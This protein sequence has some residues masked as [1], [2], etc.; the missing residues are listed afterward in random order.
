MPRQPDHIQTEFVRP[1]GR[2]VEVDEGL[3]NILDALRDHGVWTQYS[4]EGTGTKQAAYILADKKTFSPFLA[5]VFRMYKKGNLSAESTALVSSFLMGW[6]ELVFIFYVGD[7]DHTVA[8]LKFKRGVKRWPEAYSLER[9]LSNRYGDRITV[10]FPPDS[11]GAV[12]KL[13]K[14]IP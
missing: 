7:Y 9:E 3:I 10:R 2:I 4:C 1:D 6:R 11:L 13:I 5:K 12:L 8:K 14:E